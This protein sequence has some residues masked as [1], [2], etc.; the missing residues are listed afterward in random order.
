MTI[1]IPERTRAKVRQR[2]DLAYFYNPY[3]VMERVIWEFKYSNPPF[4]T[5]EVV[6]YDYAG[7]MQYLNETA[8]GDNPRYL[9]G[10]WNLWLHLTDEE[11]ELYAEY[12]E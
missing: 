12:L 5:G 2:E 11:L 8:S 6:A 4:P 7:F 1:S 3:L 10:N 9:G